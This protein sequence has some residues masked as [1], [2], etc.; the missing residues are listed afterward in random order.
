MKIEI[1]NESKNNGEIKLF[2]EKEA[3]LEAERKKCIVAFYS[4]GG[5]KEWQKKGSA[6]YAAIVF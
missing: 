4:W 1:I 3:I 5:I 2:D 6:F